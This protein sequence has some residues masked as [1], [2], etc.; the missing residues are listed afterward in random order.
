[1]QEWS[2]ILK[3]YEKNGTFLGTLME[4]SSQLLHHLVPLAE[5]A[6]M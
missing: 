6:L 1:M 4:V 3:L 5:C 2:E